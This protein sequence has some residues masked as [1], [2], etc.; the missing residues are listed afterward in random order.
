MLWLRRY[1]RISVQ[2][3]RFTPM[4]AG[5]PNISARRGRLHQPFFSQNTR[6]NDLSY[7]IKNLDRF[8]LR[9]V[10]I[11]AFVRRTGGQTDILIA[12]PRLHHMQRGKKVV[13]YCDDNVFWGKKCIRWSGS[14]IF[15]PQNDLAPLL[16]WRLHLMTCLTTLVTWKWPGC[17]DV[18]APPLNYDP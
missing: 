15:W 6:L 1:E 7:G 13:N 17:L 9:F 2:N 16:L 10:A 5:W 3:R 18:L 11:H 4:G 8:F 12:R 14:R